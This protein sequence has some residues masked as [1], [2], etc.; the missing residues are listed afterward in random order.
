MHDVLMARHVQIHVYPRVEFGKF[1][2][3]LRLRLGPNHQTLEPQKGIRRTNS[4][5][6]IDQDLSGYIQQLFQH[7]LAQ[8]IVQ[9]FHPKCLAASISIVAS[10]SILTIVKI[11]FG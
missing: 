7:H 2:I 6:S 8:K 4:V 11:G 10:T 1:Y 5:P 3:S 9:D